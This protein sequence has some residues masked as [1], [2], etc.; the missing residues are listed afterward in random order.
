MLKKLRPAE[1]SVAAQ[2]TLPDGGGDPSE[3]F[4]V[5]ARRAG[6]TIRTR[7]GEIISG[8]LDHVI[9]DLELDE[10]ECFPSDELSRELPCLL[11]H[12]GGDSSGAAETAS[13]DA[14][15]ARLASLRSAEPSIA[16]LLDDYGLL[17]RLVLEAL[18]D[19]TRGSDRA[20]LRLTLQ[21]EERFQQVVR[22]GLETFFRQRSRELQYMANT[23]PLTGLFNVRYFR[24]QLHR[25]LEM[26]KRY[27]LPFA[28]LMIDLDRLKH[29]NDALGHQAGD[30]ALRHLA[31]IMLRE[32][33]ETDIAVRYGGDEFY[34]LLPGTSESEAEYLARRLAR[35]VR[36]LNLSSGGREMTGISVG[37]V[38]CPANGVDV[39][40]LRE[41]ADRALYLAKSIG[42]DSVASYRE[43]NLRSS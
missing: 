6:E 23:D 26:Y 7:Q 3:G 41:K 13:L 11:A 17:K 16:Q 9:N 37:I 24:Q 29:L 5:L 19:D 27:R 38:S 10:L 22:S 2:S 4:A 14:A 39:S 8:W 21:M 34:L 31:E 20:L 35:C 28:L 32:K 42:G 36:K 33:R 1:E 12:L 40:T 30:T 43:F 18:A 25:N 15:A